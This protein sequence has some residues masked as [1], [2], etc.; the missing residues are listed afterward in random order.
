MP[1]LK[2]TRRVLPMNPCRLSHEWIRAEAWHADQQGALTAEANKLHDPKYPKAWELC[3][4][5]ISRSRMICSIKSRSSDQCP[6]FGAAVLLLLL[7]RM[8]LVPK[9]PA[10]LLS[11]ATLLL[12]LLHGPT[13]F[14]N[15]TPL[16]PRAPKPASE[17]HQ[18]LELLVV[19]RIILNEK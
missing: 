8:L 19:F 13:D 1:L 11:P 2:R 18:K 17:P 10:P 9:Q 12:Q 7:L 4:Y 5:S 6:I 3:S 16:I 14:R 15:P